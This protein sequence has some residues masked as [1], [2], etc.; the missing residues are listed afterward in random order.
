MEGETNQRGRNAANLENGDNPRNLCNPR[1][2][3]YPPK[4]DLHSD[5]H[6]YQHTP[7]WI[8]FSYL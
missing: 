7:A 1:F 6:T 4:C 2:A 3:A 5:E 8:E